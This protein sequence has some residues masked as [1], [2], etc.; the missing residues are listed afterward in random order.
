MTERSVPS[1]RLSEKF[2]NQAKSGVKALES[3]WQI[4]LRIAPVT[5]HK[6]KL[7]LTLPFSL[8][9]NTETLS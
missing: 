6:Q 5:F 8:L 2:P 4:V 7:I 9:H 1:T 3:A